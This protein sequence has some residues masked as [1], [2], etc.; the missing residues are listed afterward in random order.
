MRNI[1]VYTDLE[2][3]EIYSKCNNIKMYIIE[4]LITI[5]S[6][7][8]YYYYVEFCKKTSVIISVYKVINVL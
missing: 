2:F 5:R 6:G 3:M 8:Y 4:L 7:A 1:P